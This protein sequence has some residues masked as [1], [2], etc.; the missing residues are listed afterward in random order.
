[1]RLRDLSDAEVVYRIVARRKRGIP[2]RDLWTELRRRF[3]EADSREDL[4]RLVL[5]PPERPPCGSI[6]LRYLYEVGLLRDG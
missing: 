1:M 2:D 5:G 6:D 3:P 4:V